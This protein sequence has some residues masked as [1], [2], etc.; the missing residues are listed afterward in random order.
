VNESFESGWAQGAACEGRKLDD[1]LRECFFWVA[2]KAA[3]NLARSFSV[4]LPV[5]LRAVWRMACGFMFDFL[6]AFVF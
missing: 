4:L 5:W 2:R 1:E 3:F 6:F